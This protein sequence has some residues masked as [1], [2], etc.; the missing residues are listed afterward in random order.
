LQAAKFSRSWGNLKLLK[1]FF[2]LIL[3]NMPGFVLATP[4]SQSVFGDLSRYNDINTVDNIFANKQITEKLQALLGTHY[5]EFIIN[6]V[7]TGEPH[8]TAEG[9]IFVEGWPEHLYREQASAL[10][11]EP[12][13][14]LYAAW[15]KPETNKIEYRSSEGDNR[16]IHR[17]LAQWATRF[18]HMTF[19][20]E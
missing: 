3:L 8:L 16:V 2:L 17:E 10:V 15:K 14:R 12:D 1:S 9:G 7:G 6:F 20:D 11:I 4:S 19:T 18:D 5:A 13:G